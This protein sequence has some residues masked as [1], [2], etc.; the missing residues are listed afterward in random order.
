MKKITTLLL[1]F[2][3]LF[4]AA[5][6]VTANTKVSNNII[7]K[8]SNEFSKIDDMKI[9]DYQL[10]KNI[11]KEK[12]YML[13]QF[14]NNS[15]GIIYLPTMVII[16]Y[17]KNCDL[18][19][20][21]KMKNMDFY[22]GPL[23]YY[24]Q[25]DI[26][27]YEHLYS[28][29]SVSKTE[30]RKQSQLLDQDMIS[31]KKLE[32]KTENR[33]T[34]FVSNDHYFRNCHT[35]PHNEDSCGAVALSILL[36]Y[37][38]TFCNGNTI[39]DSYMD[40]AEMNSD[41]TISDCI[42]PCGNNSLHDKLLF[43]RHEEFGENSNSLYSSQVETVFNDYMNEYC[44]NFQNEFIENSSLCPSKMRCK[45][46]ID[47]N[48]PVLLFIGWCDAEGHF[49]KNYNHVVVAYGYKTIDSNL[50]FA[51]HMGWHGYSTET[52]VHPHTFLGLGGQFNI[53]YTGDHVHAYNYC[54]NNSGCKTYY[55]GADGENVI[56][57]NFTYQYYNESFHTKICAVCGYDAGL[58]Y[59]EMVVWPG[60][61]YKCIK[62]N[63][64]TSSIITPR[65]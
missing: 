2:L 13:C 48:R 1:A 14:D 55:C 21:V 63:Y 56:H 36:S 39:N 61:R 11:D 60:N 18:E 46:I 15:L 40:T 65:N 50:Y 51:C 59:H 54:Y 64:I 57:H 16:E 28:N 45:Q 43:Y 29:E 8:V 12:K 58:E 6:T 20:Y 62:C 30:L 42:S 41:D 35:F 31:Y 34:I 22:G 52:Y 9:K 38:D 5:F 32:I 33:D 27:K 4:G 3:I 25:I 10:L 49:T 44:S 7:D 19:T 47:D 53:E 37:Y 17:L 26:S 23:N 24:K